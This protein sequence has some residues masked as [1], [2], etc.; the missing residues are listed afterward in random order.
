M[1]NKLKTGLMLGLFTAAVSATAQAAPI[2]IG[3]FTSASGF[4]S[5]NNGSLTG[6]TPGAF[7]FSPE[8]EA[9]LGAPAG[10]FLNA[11]LTVNAT[12]TGSIT[13]TPLPSPPFP[14]GTIFLQ[15]EFAG[16]I[17]I[18]D[19]GGALLLRTDFSDSNLS[20]LQGGDT[21]LLSGAT[22]TGASISY[23]S[24]VL[25]T[26]LLIDPQAF[27]FILTPTNPVLSVN[28]P[29]F[30]NFTAPDSANFSSDVTVAPEPGLL[31][32]FGLGLTAVGTMVRRRRA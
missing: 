2:Q 20:G 26:A 6:T 23:S 31:A 18:R 5:Y 27:Q 14:A 15:Q 21:A 8:A 28:G 12:A 17:E 19:S 25:N 32:L 3:S 4:Y 1:F 22:Q 11:T 10:T 7:D 16:Y 29:N 24:A 9:L 13:S 30:T